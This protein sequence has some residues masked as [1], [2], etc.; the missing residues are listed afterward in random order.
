MIQEKSEMRVLSLAFRLGTFAI[1]SAAIFSPVSIAVAAPAASIAG[2]WKGPFLS[3]NFTFEFTQAGT[4][5]TGR[6]QSE[7]YGKWVDLENVSFTDGALRFSFPSK[8][9]SNF[10]LKIDSKGKALNGTGKFGEMDVPL[11]LTRAS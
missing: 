11:A 4:G 8:P 9:P 10:T 1:A 7:K 2:S 5:W 3:T 6:Y